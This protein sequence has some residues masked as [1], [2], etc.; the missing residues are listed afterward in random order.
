MSNNLK[1]I[2]LDH[3]INL[4]KLDASVFLCKINDNSIKNLNLVKLFANN[5]KKIIHSF[6][7]TINHL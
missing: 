7:T 6:I 4:Q 1:I 5:N 3:M 2:N